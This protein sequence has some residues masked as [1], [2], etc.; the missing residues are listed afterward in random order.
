MCT[1][2][3]DAEKVFN[4]KKVLA[5]GAI[6][7]SEHLPEYRDGWVDD[8]RTIVDGDDNKTTQI[9]RRFQRALIEECDFTNIE[10]KRL[11]F[12]GMGENEA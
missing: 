10:M 4:E 12:T 8:I 1:H 6:A 11:P 3:Y 9:I 2:T 5:W 7:T